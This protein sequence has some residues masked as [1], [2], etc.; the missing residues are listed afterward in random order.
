MRG[1]GTEEEAE[2]EEEEEEEPRRAPVCWPG[3]AEDTR[4]EA[5]K[6]RTLANMLLPRM[7]GNFKIS[8][9]DEGKSPQYCRY[10]RRFSQ[11]IITGVQRPPR[12]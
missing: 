10:L 4:G 6:R 12:P 5:E 11:G 7:V 9:D 3:E 8:V 1:G 2:E